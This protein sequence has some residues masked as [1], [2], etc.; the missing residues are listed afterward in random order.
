MRYGRK[1]GILSKWGLPLRPSQQFRT[2]LQPARLVLCGYFGYI[3]FIDERGGAVG[4]GHKN[5]QYPIR[6]CE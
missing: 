3:K 5:I 6:N 2:D 4:G 1:G